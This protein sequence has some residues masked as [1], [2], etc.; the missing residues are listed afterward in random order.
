MKG[1]KKQMDLKKIQIPILYY[2]KVSYENL[3]SQLFMNL[4]ISSQVLL[5]WGSILGLT[6]PL[7]SL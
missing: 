1:G 5:I 2:E 7:C 6:C 4:L 3:Y